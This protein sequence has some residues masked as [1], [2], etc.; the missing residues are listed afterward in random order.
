M[1]GM[2]SIQRK[3][4]LVF[5]ILLIIIA[6]ASEY[7]HD[8]VLQIA[9]DYGGSPYHYSILLE[10]SW[11]YESSGILGVTIRKLFQLRAWLY[12]FG[13]LMIVYWALA[14]RHE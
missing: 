14:L 9:A 11:V 8:I 7:A 1:L 2:R 10:E 13:F 4:W 5:G 3:R 6:I 12:I